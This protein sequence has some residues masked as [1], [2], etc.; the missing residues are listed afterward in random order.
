MAC[1]VGERLKVGVVTTHVRSNYRLLEA[2]SRVEYIDMERPSLE[3]VLQAL[4]TMYKDPNTTH[5]KRDEV[6]KWLSQ[7]QSSVS[8]SIKMRK[9]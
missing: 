9:L 7:L 2:W 5:E 1:S 3:I 4:H 6:N 8:P